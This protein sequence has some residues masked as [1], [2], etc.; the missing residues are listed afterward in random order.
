MVFLR[1]GLLSA[2]VLVIGFAA[3][4]A[5]QDV[6]GDTCGGSDLIDALE[7]AGDEG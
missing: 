6:P 3:P 5:A 7:S 1:S 2:L 4:M